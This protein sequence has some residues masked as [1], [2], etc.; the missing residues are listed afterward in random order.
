MSEFRIKNSF[1]DPIL[2]SQ[3]L[4]DLML[5]IK[6]QLSN[7]E[8]ARSRIYSVEKSVREGK[9][10]L[11]GYKEDIGSGGSIQESLALNDAE[12]KLLKQFLELKNELA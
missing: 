11:T 12:D 6:N 2:E 4:K 5:E 1:V 3:K 9:L 7:L 10:D 8:K